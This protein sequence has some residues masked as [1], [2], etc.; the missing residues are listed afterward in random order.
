MIT[1]IHFSPEDFHGCGQLIIRNSSPVDSSDLLFAISVCYKVGYLLNGNKGNN[2]LLISMADGYSSCFKS[3][4]ELCEFLNNDKW[5][6]RPM[7]QTEIR[8][9]IGRQGSRFN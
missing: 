1:K 2:I 7:T 4:A 9:I 5:G 6:Y 3:K 8:N